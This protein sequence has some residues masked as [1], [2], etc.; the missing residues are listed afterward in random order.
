MCVA[1][2]AAEISRRCD[3]QSSVCFSHAT[4]YTTTWKENVYLQE[5]K[6]TKH[7]PFIKSQFLIGLNISSNPV[8]SLLFQHVISIT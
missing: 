5:D 6:E 4:L 2:N 8:P 3:F 7:G 1:S